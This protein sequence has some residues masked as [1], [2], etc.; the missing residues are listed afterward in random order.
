MG[1]LILFKEREYDIY[2]F[3]INVPTNLGVIDN[4]NP[5]NLFKPEYTWTPTNTVGNHIALFTNGGVRE[6]QNYDSNQVNIS[7]YSSLEFKINDKIKSVV[8]L[9]VENFIQKIYWRK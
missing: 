3:R 1:H 8:G 5:D 4:G 9:R 6:G 2:S 7:G